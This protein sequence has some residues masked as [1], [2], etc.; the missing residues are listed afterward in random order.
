MAT[1]V[2][3]LTTTTQEQF[4]EALDSVQATILEGVKLWSATVKSL[5]PEDLPKTLPVPGVDWLP[6]PSEY[7]DLGFGFFE[8]LLASQKGFAEQVVA[9]TA[10]VPPNVKPAKTTVS[11]AK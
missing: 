10:T 2:K 5:V 4:F 8:K 6:S 7:V 3:D 9:E 11:S 1:D